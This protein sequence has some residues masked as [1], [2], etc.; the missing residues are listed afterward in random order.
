MKMV[1]DDVKTLFERFQQIDSEIALLREDKKEI[2]EEF[3]DRVEPKVFRA[4]LASA[5][6]KAK[7]KPQES[8]DYDQVLLLLEDVLCVEHVE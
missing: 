5:K 4:A 8:N 2:L 6:R 7:L 3:K 1:N